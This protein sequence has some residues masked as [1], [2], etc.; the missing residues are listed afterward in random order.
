M[1]FSID[2]DQ[3]TLSVCVPVPSVPA[4]VLPSTL[5]IPSVNL[6][7]VPQALSR[8]TDL[9]EDI[10]GLATSLV[11]LIPEYAVALELKVGGVT[12]LDETITVPV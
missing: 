9:A 1:A 12:L 6:P 11:D 7:D 8:V 5:A 3:M 2:E 4:V 10:L